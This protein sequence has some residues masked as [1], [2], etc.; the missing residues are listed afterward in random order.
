MQH[1]GREMQVASP[2][3]SAKGLGPGCFFFRGGGADRP[4]PDYMGRGADPIAPSDVI[5]ISLASHNYIGHVSIWHSYIG[6]E[7]GRP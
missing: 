3:P 6:Q 2:H 4:N 7:L 5:G 1:A